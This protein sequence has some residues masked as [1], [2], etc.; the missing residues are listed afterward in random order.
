[1]L[2]FHLPLHG[3][4]YFVK[5][6]N[7]SSQSCNS[8]DRLQIF[9]QVCIFSL[10]VQKCYGIKYWQFQFLT[11]KKF[12]PLL[13]FSANDKQ[14]L[15][16]QKTRYSGI[17][18][19]FLAVRHKRMTTV[20]E[21]EARGVWEHAPAPPPAIWSTKSAPFKCLQQIII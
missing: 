18:K 9:I 10:S 3:Y 20:Q 11:A 6:V 14:V 21:K 17:S 16:L 5:H 8:K 1:M 12:L 2:L 15:Q 13:N 7:N 19:C 4:R